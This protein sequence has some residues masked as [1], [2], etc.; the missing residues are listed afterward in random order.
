MAAA[1]HGA[2]WSLASHADPTGMQSAENLISLAAILAVTLLYSTTGGLRAVVATDVVQFALAMLGTAVYTVVVV[3]AAGG[4]AHLPSALADRYGPMFA[5][6][7]LAFTPS[8]AREAGLALLAVIGIQWIA[9]MNTDGTGSLAQRAMACRSDA[10]A[11]R[12]ALVFVGAQVIARSLLWIPLG[13]GLMLLYPLDSGTTDAAAV[14]AREAIYVTG[15][16]DLMPA[17]LRGLLLTGMLAALASTLDSHLNW[18]ASYFTNDLYK[19]LYC[20]TLRG[21]EPSERVLVRVARLSNAV[22]L[23]LVIALLVRLESVQHAWTTTL[24]LGA[25]MGVPLLLRWFWWRVTA[26]G[27]LSAICVG[28]VL[29]PL[30]LYRVDGEAIRILAMTAVSTAVVVGIAFAGARQPGPAPLG[31][32]RR[33]RTGRRERGGWTCRTLP[34]PRWIA[35]T[36]DPCQV[37]G[38]DIPRNRARHTTAGLRRS[39]PPD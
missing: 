25:G 10:D 34:G 38:R 18:G 31:F 11:C 13:L 24:L 26:A 27:E 36:P 16:A 15:I 2:G 17:G 33:V 8:H 19:R 35:R 20:E 5:S 28:S 7:T 39:E 6:E 37:C 4:L 12:A 9:Q 32:Y 1:V 3:S 30:L 22:I 23:V 29:A 21:R 14:A